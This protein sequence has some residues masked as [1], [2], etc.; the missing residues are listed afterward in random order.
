MSIVEMGKMKYI[1]QTE[2]PGLGKQ[3]YVNHKEEGSA[4]ENSRF[5]PKATEHKV[6]VYLLGKEKLEEIKVKREIKDLTP[7]ILGLRYL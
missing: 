6:M 3:L 5:F 2:P 4:K 7:D 1:L